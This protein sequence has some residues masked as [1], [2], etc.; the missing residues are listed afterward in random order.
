[1]IDLSPEF[2]V[3]VMLGSILVGVLAGFP[4]GFVV[5]FVAL[6]GGY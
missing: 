1:M 4:L 2:L 6:A 5:G 3:I